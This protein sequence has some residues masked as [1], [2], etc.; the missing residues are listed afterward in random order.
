MKNL[1]VKCLLGYLLFGLSATCMVYSQTNSIGY[2][3]SFDNPS[4]HWQP[5][6]LSKTQG[7]VKTAE[8]KL[9]V[10]SESKKAFGAYYAAESF[11]GHFEVEVSFEEGGKVGLALLRNNHGVPDQDNFTMLTVSVNKNGVQEVKLRDRQN[12]KA[13][14]WDHTTLAK[15]SRYVHQLTGKQYSVP[16]TSTAGRIR[17]FRH[18]REHFFHFYY[19]VEKE[20]DGQVYQ[21]WMELAPSKEWGTPSDTYFVG[22]F[23]LEGEAQFEEVEVRQLPVADQSDL[24][25]G[26]EV[27]KRAYT[28]S[29]YTD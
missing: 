6:S 11:S 2:S 19:A 14:V 7:A 22:L 9:L 17:V 10:S 3:D 25:T 12:G 20:V 15:R 1:L 8:G 16:F 28:W 23:A 27:N 18:A 4:A 5:V 13:N 26:F 29:G 21:N 24:E